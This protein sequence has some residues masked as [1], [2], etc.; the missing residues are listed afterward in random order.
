MKVV[1]VPR[2]PR[3][4]TFWRKSLAENADLTARVARAKTLVHGQPSATV[5]QRAQATIQVLHALRTNMDAWKRVVGPAVQADH[6]F[7][8]AARKMLAWATAIYGSTV[9]EEQ[10]NTYVLTGNGIA[11][12]AASLNAIKQQ[13]AAAAK[14]WQDAQAVPVVPQGGE[15]VYPNGGGAKKKSKAPLVVLALGALAWAY[16]RWGRR[17]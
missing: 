8:R 13:N 12:A 4:W 2:P 14:A 15:S 5:Y 16:N 1:V 6:A 11:I 3:G 17:R 10:V 9:Y 7:Q